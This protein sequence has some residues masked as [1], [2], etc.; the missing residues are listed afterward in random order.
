MNT[1]EIKTIIDSILAGITKLFTN[2]TFRDKVERYIQQKYDAGLLH[3][4]ELFEI[5][6]VRNDRELSFLHDYVN[7]LVGNTLEQINQDLRAEL[8]RAILSGEDV[9]QIK[10]RVR[11]VFRDPKYY[12]RLTMVLRTEGLRAGNTAAMSGA[13]QSG[14]K[15]KKWLDVV[16]DDRTS[17]ICHKEHGKYGSK[18]KAIP[19]DQEF[20]V[21]V[22]NKTIRGKNPPFHPNCRTVIRFTED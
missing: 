17:D 11:D 3:A 4:E 7:G 18:D 13:E 5:N 9:Q 14:L 20:T 16:L 19:L 8:Q 15:L 21:K 12:N 6:F 2:E 1:P 10:K 22:D